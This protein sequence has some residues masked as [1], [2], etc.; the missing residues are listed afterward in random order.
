MPPFKKGGSF[1]RFFV[2]GSMPDPSAEDFFEALA[3]ERFRSIE[4]A[5]SEETS[6][7]WVSSS[8]PSGQDFLREDVLVGDFVRLRMRMDKK[9]LP[10]A[11]LAIHMA[12]EIR[13][14][15]GQKISAKERKTIRGD[16]EDRVLPRTLPN[17]SFV[18]VVYVPAKSQVLL[19]STSA[20]AAAECAKL[21]HRSFGVSLEEVDPT[22]L[23]QRSSLPNEKK[24][25]LDQCSP[26]SLR[27]REQANGHAPERPAVAAPAAA[28]AASAGSA[29]EE[30]APWESNPPLAA[31]PPAEAGPPA[32]ASAT[33]DDRPSEGQAS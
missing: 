4:N 10:A 14:R 24:R 20:S 1:V 16:I 18:E 9:K 33:M 23:A 6:V 13:A 19:F 27:E 12:A 31:N 5:A 21:F 7:G 17:V 15:D 11:W 29:S 25:Y 26:F 22:T 32:E 3:R 28:Q 8:D 2:E 30:G